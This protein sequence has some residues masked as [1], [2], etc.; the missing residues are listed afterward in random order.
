M[1]EVFERKVFSRVVANSCSP[2]TNIHDTRSHTGQYFLITPK[3]LP[4]LNDMDNENV[5]VLFIFNG[6]F[7]NLGNIAMGEMIEKRKRAKVTPEK[8]GNRKEKRAK[9]P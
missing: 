2:L 1:D 6:P 3:L 8:E 9:V 7:M 4:N 5:T